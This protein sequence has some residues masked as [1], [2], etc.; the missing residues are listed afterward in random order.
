MMKWGREGQDR[1]T[2]PQ[3][4]K[5]GQAGSPMIRLQ[6]GKVGQAGGPKIRPMTGR[7]GDLMIHG[8]L[9]AQSDL[10]IGALEN[11]CPLGL[12]PGSGHVWF[13]VLL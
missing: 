13:R 1:V 2:Q 5:V 7:S 10:A 3:P 4:G 6:L 11:N 12:K 9:G 8:K